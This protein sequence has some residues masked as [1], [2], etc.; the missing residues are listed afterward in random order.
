LEQDV[1]SPQQYRDRLLLETGNKD[2]T[3]VRNLFEGYFWKHEVEMTK[4]NGQLDRYIYSI[5]SEGI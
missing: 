4:R 3:D 5:T 2:A 1:E